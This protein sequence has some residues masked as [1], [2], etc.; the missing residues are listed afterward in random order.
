M[1]L[2]D[3][4]LKFRKDKGMTREQL[5][6]LTDIPVVSLGRYERNEREPQLEVIIKIASALGI[7]VN[8]L[9]KFNELSELDELDYG[10]VYLNNRESSLK[11]REKELEASLENLRNT[12]HILSFI[13]EHVQ[14]FK[15]KIKNNAKIDDSD[16][17][18]M[19]SYL[20]ELSV[21]TDTIMNFLQI[22]KLNEI[23]P[24]EEAKFLSNIKLIDIDCSDNTLFVPEDSDIVRR[25]I[26]KLIKHL[27]YD[28]DDISRDIFDKLVK[29]L[30]NN[31]DYQFYNINKDKQK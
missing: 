26:L 19:V 25:D 28:L 30:I 2:G 6:Q 21:Q 3:N 27:H 14:E 17:K 11:A 9:A 7:S 5:S 15:D 1:K 29:E 23:T 31:I 16:Y 10:L 12:Q 22:D 20:K 13:S 4:I 8:E 18:S 24:D